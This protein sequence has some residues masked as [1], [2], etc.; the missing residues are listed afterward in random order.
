[1]EE[2]NF[3]TYPQHWKDISETTL[4]WVGKTK[5][6]CAQVKGPPSNNRKAKQT[7][8][9]TK[10]NNNK[11]TNRTQNKPLKPGLIEPDTPKCSNNGF[12]FGGK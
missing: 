4:G 12:H 6:C 11:K 10:Q 8:R 1:M 9:K 5:R 7:W 2:G 3:L